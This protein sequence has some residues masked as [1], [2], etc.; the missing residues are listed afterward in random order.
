M[1]YEPGPTGDYGADGIPREGMT[2]RYATA[3]WRDD[4]SAFWLHPEGP[5]SDTTPDE[6]FVPEPDMGGNG[7]IGMADNRL[8][9]NFPGHHYSQAYL[10]NAVMMQNAQTVYQ[11]YVQQQMGGQSAVTPFE[12][13]WDFLFPR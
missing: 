9:A 5:L 2:E 13:G 4:P 8:Y 3:L 11:N 10:Q 12:L 6:Y 1:R 7:V